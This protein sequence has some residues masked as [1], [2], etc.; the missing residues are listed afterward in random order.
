MLLPLARH[1]RVGVCVGTGV[2][3]AARTQMLLQAFGPAHSARSLA[4]LCKQL[5][6]TSWRRHAC[7]PVRRARI[8]AWAAHRQAADGSIR[9]AAA[10]TRG[11][12]AGD[13]TRETVPDKGVFVGTGIRA[14]VRGANYNE[15]R[16]NTRRHDKSTRE[17]AGVGRVHVVETAHH[18]LSV[19]FN[20]AHGSA[21]QAHRTRIANYYSD[22]RGH[23]L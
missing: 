20:A 13:V 1:S 12:R 21:L 9:R 17:G 5:A 7:G 4:R 15:D 16:V 14:R 23:N 6:L 8:R 3:V 22:C 18:T 2:G 11:C 19:K 10:I